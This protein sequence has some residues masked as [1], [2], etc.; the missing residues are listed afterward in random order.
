[1]LSGIVSAAAL[2]QPAP[3]STRAAWALVVTCRLISCRCRHMAS[4]LTY[5]STSPAL[6]ASLGKPR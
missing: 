4:A 1:M 3:S 6:V 2:C 5:G